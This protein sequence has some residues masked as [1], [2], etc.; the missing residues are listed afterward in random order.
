[1]P[2]VLH[3]P[4]IS[5]L[6]GSYNIWQGVQFMKLL[7]MQLTSASCYFLLLSSKYFPYNHDLTHY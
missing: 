6:F 3:A 5:F 1:L 4:P 2:W 7:I